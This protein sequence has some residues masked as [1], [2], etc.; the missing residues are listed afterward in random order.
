MICQVEGCFREPEIELSVCDECLR[1]LNLTYSDSSRLF[2]ADC[3]PHIIG[4]LPSKYH[5]A[6]ARKK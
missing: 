4:S 1:K 3:F 5:V 2:A 6:Y